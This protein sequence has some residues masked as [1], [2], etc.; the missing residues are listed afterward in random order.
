MVTTDAN[1]QPLDQFEQVETMLSSFETLLASARKATGPLPVDL[2]Q[3]FDGMIRLSRM[4]LV[5]FR[6]TI[7]CLSGEAF[8]AANIVGAAGLE[9]LL[10]LMCLMKKEEVERTHTWQTIC[11]R[12]PKPFFKTLTSTD[13]AKLVEVGREL[14]WFPRNGVP[15]L[16]TSILSQ[17]IG[18][19]ATTK[20]VSLM[21]HTED[22]CSFAAEISRRTRDSL[23]AGRCL[24]ENIEL[25]LETGIAA[26]VFMMLCLCGFS[27][28]SMQTQP[29]RTSAALF[30]W[31]I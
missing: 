29:H 7:K 15:Q 18:I 13:L 22:I 26:S 1:L 19:E 17:H 31:K 6:E 14:N 23:H 30:G 8:F 2:D 20:L 25:S 28:V 24:R 11:K 12:K 3:Q 9:S 21:P 27:E 16:F 4:T 5:H 10:T